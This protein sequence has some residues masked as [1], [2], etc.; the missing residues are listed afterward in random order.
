[1]KITVI[2]DL[3]E[4]YSNEEGGSFTQEIKQ[5]IA[6]QV[7]R[8][9]LADFKA[10]CEDQFTSKVVEEVEKAKAKFIEGT[11]KKLVV[12]AKIKKRYSNNEMISISEYMQEDLEST[13]I[14]E[15]ER[16]MT[17]LISKS[18]KQPKKYLRS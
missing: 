9:V 6:R 7:K 1:M 10:K 18:K 11:L 15:R 16:L 3:S 12:D 17:F 8:E 5:E 13:Y 2:V 14:N 4:M